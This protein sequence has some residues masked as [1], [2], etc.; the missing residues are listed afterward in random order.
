MTQGTDNYWTRLNGGRFTRRRFVGGAAA[1]GAGAAALGLVGCGDDDD[2]AG[3][4]TS[5]SGGASPS[6][7]SA[8]T[9]ATATSSAAQPI[10]GGT[11]RF[12][13]ANNTFDTFDFDR[14]IFSTIA[15]YVADVCNL[16]IVHY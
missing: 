7:G 12:T 16:G 2:N 10:K 1:A 9:A 11:A 3:S 14:S 13:T 4:P 6:G 5:S 8:T 15:Y